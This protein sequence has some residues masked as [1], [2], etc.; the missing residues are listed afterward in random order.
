M[1]NNT[2]QF[3][4]SNLGW[5]QV[6]YADGSLRL[7]YD[8]MEKLYVDLYNAGIYLQPEGMA[9][10]SKHNCIDQWGGEIYAGD[11]LAFAYTSTS[12]ST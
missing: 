1:K 4:F 7:Q 6:D 3:S 12:S 2:H 10:F 5:W 11:T 8:R 9:V